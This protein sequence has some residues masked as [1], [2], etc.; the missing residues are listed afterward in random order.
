PLV[1][2]KIVAGSK[3]VSSQVSRFLCFVDSHV[4][5]TSSFA[6]CPAQENIGYISTD[7]KSGD[8][9]SLYQLMRSTLKEQPVLKRSGFHF[10]S[11]A[12][13]I[14]WPWAILGNKTPFESGWESGSAPPSQI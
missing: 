2:R 14:A 3:Y 6:I 9:H 7:S 4:D 12:N 13:K 11:I 5:D 8:D 1:H 10:I